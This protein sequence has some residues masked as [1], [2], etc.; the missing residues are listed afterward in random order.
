[1]TRHTPKFNKKIE[2]HVSEKDIRFLSQVGSQW[3][4]KIIQNEC[5]KFCGWVLQGHQ[6]YTKKGYFIVL[7][8]IVKRLDKCLKIGLKLNYGRGKSQ[9]LRLLLRLGACLTL[10]TLVYH[11]CTKYWFKDVR[12]AQMRYLFGLWRGT[13]QNCVGMFQFLSPGRS[14]NPVVKSWILLKKWN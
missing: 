5:T 3:G 14:T 9:K 1:M 12:I 2:S 8:T 10:H 7:Q 11:K 13:C 6:A 4:L